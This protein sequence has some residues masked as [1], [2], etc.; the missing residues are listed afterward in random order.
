MK[1]ESV[2]QNNRISK[3]EIKQVAD[4]VVQY[5]TQQRQHREN[6]IPKIPLQPEHVEN[7]ELLLNRQQLLDKMKKNSVV[8]EIGVDEGKFSQLIHKKVK[9]RKFHLIDMWGSDRFHDG[10]FEAVKDYFA[11]EIV[12]DTVQIHKKMSTKAAHDFE[13]EYFDWIYID[14]DHS[15]ETTRDELQLY[16]PKMK[17]GG[18]MAGHDYRMGNWVSMYRYGVIEAVHEFCVKQNWEILYLTSEP[19]ESQSF[20]IRK[21]DI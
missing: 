1:N 17:P 19:T 18:I 2:Q 6:Q 20:A 4:K 14:T 15:Y 16:A 11:E 13:N 21:I 3:N 10:K 8:A 7:C 5:L 12:E 9:P